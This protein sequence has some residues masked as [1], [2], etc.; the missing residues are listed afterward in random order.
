MDKRTELEAVQAKLFEMQQ[1]GIDNL[2]PDEWETFEG[3][4]NRQQAL[5]KELYT[6]TTLEV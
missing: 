5:M 3:L 6:I 1:V 2:G 4:H